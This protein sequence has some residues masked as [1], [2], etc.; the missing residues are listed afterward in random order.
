ML[1]LHSWLLIVIL[2]RSRL[3]FIMMRYDFVRV[4]LT[5][6][7]ITLFSDAAAHLT[8]R[9]VAATDATTPAW[10]YYGCWRYDGT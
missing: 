2:A 9:Q 6:L 10:Q 1:L 8:K 5:L 7:V 4:T 3:L